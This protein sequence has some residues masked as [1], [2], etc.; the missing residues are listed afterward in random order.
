[1]SAPRKPVVAI[2]GPAGAGKSTVARLLAARLGYVLI[3]TGA[4]YRAVALA[5]RERGTSRDDGPA[6]GRLARELT[7]ELVPGPDGFPRI[8]VEGRER[9]G[10]I[11][12][13]EI[14]R[15]ASAV[16]RHPEVRKALLD[17]QRGLGANGGAVVEGRDIGTVV[18]PD[19]EVKIFLTASPEVRAQ[20]RVHEL[21]ERGTEADYDET[22]AAIRAR[23]AQDG[24]RE[25]APLKPADDAVEVDTTEL[26]AGQVL[27]HIEALVRRH[28]EAT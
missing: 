26:D 2:D 19:A 3:D 18:F 22:L 14:S 11:R 1:M 4:L 5:A 25:V 12:T 28:V 9:S 27:D 23:D 10:D 20:R 8:F 16:S 17:T 13:P 15:D 7:L 24:G 6:L 21:R